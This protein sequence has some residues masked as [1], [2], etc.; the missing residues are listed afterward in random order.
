MNK[1]EQVLTHY[2]GTMA[3][4]AI[5]L[6]NGVHLVTRLVTGLPLVE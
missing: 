1:H 4:A 3:H 6:C 2:A 5:V